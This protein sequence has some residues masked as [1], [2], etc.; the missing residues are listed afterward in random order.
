MTK[1]IQELKQRIEQGKIPV[2]YEHYA[3]FGLT[4]TDDPK[5]TC[6]EYD[7]LILT[8]HAS[9]WSWLVASMRSAFAEKL[10]R[11]S[12]DDFH[13]E[14]AEDIL[15]SFK[16][17][18]DLFDAMLFVISSAENRYFKCITTYTEFNNEPF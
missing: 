6:D 3:D 4:I 14:I 13:R 10:R 2:N 7:M 16:T 18:G 5:Q 9:A 1:K 15:S 12:Y 8:R 11:R 17:D